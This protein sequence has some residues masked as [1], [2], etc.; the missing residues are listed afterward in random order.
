M[1]VYVGIRASLCLEKRSPVLAMF[2]LSDCVLVE[3]TTYGALGLLAYL[4]NQPQLWNSSY[5][6]QTF[7]R[8]RRIFIS[9]T[10][11]L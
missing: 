9:K 8:F 2:Q 5:D 3:W 10:S 11:Y 7:P 1:K 6:R 4:V